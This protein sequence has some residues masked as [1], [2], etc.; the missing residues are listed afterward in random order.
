MKELNEEGHELVDGK[1]VKLYEIRFTGSIILTPEEASSIASGDSVSCFVNGRVQP[2]KFSLVKK[3]GEMKRQNVIKLESLVP[4]DPDRAT[5][6]LDNL[7]LKING[8]NDG[9]VDTVY[10]LPEEEQELG[11]DATQ[12]FL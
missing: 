5:Q 12:A 9:I 4:L 1:A 8:V 3:T 7:D 10:V 6:V 11:F 2:P